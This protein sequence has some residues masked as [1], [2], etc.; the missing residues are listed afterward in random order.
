MVLHFL[1][2]RHLPSTPT[3]NRCVNIIKNMENTDRFKPCNVFCVM[4]TRC[5]L[6]FSAPNPPHEDDPER[7]LTPSI[8]FASQTPLDHLLDPHLGD[9]LDH[10]QILWA[11]LVFAETFH[12]VGCAVIT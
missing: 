4:S 11:P 7:S 8:S 5:F 12:W 2:Q 9:D 3:L 10:P 6:L 1:L